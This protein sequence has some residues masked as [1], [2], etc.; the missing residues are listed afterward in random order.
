MFVFVLQGG[1]GVRR[2][3][4]KMMVVVVVV[5]TTMRM[6]MMRTMTV[7]AIM[8]RLLCFKRHK[9]TSCHSLSVTRQPCRR[10]LLALAPAHRDDGPRVRPAAHVSQRGSRRTSATVMQNA[11]KGS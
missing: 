5:M 8:T 6:R 1:E 7:L 4:K 9:S 11:I 2:E 3:E 10:T